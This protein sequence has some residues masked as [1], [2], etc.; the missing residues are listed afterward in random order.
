ELRVA[1]Q[2]VERPRADVAHAGAEAADE[3]LDDEGERALVGHAAL[4]ALGHELHA[5]LGALLVLHV[6]VP[7]AFALAHRFEGAH[8]AIEL[9]GAALVQ[10]RLARALLGAGEEP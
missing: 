5:E 2:V 9:V 7:A 1:R 8:A 6:A 10:D 3:L 4:D